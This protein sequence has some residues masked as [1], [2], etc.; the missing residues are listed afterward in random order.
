MEKKKRPVLLIIIIL[1]LVACIGCLLVELLLHPL[2]RTYD[3]LILDNYN[4]YLPC[5]ALPA[6][7]KVLEVMDQYRDDITRIEQVDPGSVGVEVDTGTCP[8]KGDLVIWYATH[9][10]RLLVEGMLDGKTFHDI[11]IR[12]QNR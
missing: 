4:H 10:D 6:Q 7:E 5:S 11:P 9:A 12:L 8:G 1:I 3:N 2:R